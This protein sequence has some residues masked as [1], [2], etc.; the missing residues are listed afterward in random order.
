MQSPPNSGPSVPVHPPTPYPRPHATVLVPGLP[1]N[2][3]NPSPAVVLDQHQP[4]HPPTPYPRPHATPMDPGLFTRATTPSPPPPPLVASPSCKGPPSTPPVLGGAMIN[5]MAP[6][7]QGTYR[8]STPQ[9]VRSKSTSPLAHYQMGSQSVPTNMN[10]VRPKL[11]PLLMPQRTSPVFSLSTP[12]LSTPLTI[13]LPTPGVYLGMATPLSTSSP[14][15]DFP[16]PS[17]SGGGLILSPEAKK[18]VLAALRQR[19]LSPDSTVGM[20]LEARCS[21][22]R[23]KEFKHALRLFTLCTC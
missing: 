2:V 10:R 1:V 8:P 17:L 20:F 21:V 13:P 19:L 16:T 7:G 18:Q 4:T 9:P 11:A 22:A 6:H 5:A 12:T 3:P 23:P 14:N 15:I